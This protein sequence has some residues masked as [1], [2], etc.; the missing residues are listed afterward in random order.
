MDVRVA[1][2]PHVPRRWQR[3]GFDASTTGHHRWTR[4]ADMGSGGCTVRRGTHTY[5]CISSSLQL[6][7]P[8]ALPSFPFR[9]GPATI[10]FS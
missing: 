6:A 4:R 5:T 8:R 1:P 2:V 3:E 7:L 10:P 9:A